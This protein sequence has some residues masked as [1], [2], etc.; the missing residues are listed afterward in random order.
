M[1]S[2]NTNNYVADVEDRK[3]I[4]ENFQKGLVLNSTSKRTRKKPKR[5]SDM[6]FV[7]GSNN[8]YTKGR[9]D[10]YDRNYIG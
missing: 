3:L 7:R 10:Q 5:Y 6:V 8:Q 9:V 1:S 4:Y 2:Y